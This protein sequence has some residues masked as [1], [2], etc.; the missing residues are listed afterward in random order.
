MIIKN[1]N[2]VA[3]ETT[4]RGKVVVQLLTRTNVMYAYVYIEGREHPIQAAIEEVVDYDTVTKEEKDMLDTL[5]DKLYEI[6]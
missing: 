3:E 5:E 2:T 4:T 1:N 6:N